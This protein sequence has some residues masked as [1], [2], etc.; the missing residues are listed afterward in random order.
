MKTLLVLALAAAGSFPAWLWATPAEPALE[1]VMLAG[2]EP[3][4]KL[5]AINYQCRAKGKSPLNQRISHFRKLLIAV[6]FALAT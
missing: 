6:R 1:I 4:H 5:R 3:C 2:N